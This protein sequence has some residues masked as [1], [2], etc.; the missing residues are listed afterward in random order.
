M[1]LAL[2]NGSRDFVAGLAK[3][4]ER[5]SSISAAAKLDWRRTKESATQLFCPK[6]GGQFEV[7]N[8][9]PMKPEIVDYCARDVA[10]LP[11]LYNA[12]NAKL[13]REATKDRIKLSQSPD[14]DGQASTEVRGP[15][16]K[17]AIER[18]I[19][20]WNDDL[21]MGLLNDEDE[22]DDFDYDYGQYLI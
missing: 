19:E 10:Q 3:C 5:D 4:V 12:Y 8:Y 21:L 11:G 1:E 20:I 15:W 14:Y 22:D 13:L 17:L 6:K 16:S 18:A 7:F 2:R 9:R